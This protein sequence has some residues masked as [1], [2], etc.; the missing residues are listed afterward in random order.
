MEFG[1]KFAE[2]EKNGKKYSRRKCM[3][4]NINYE[5]SWDPKFEFRAAFSESENRQKIRRHTEY[6]HC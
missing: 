2:K 4:L 6:T 1:N 3:Y 5:F